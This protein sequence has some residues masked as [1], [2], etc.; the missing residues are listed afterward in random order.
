MKA[1]FALALALFVGAC[2][3]SCT[4]IDL[5][6]NLC[7]G[8]YD[9]GWDARVAPSFEACITIDPIEQIEYVVVSTTTTTTLEEEDE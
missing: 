1:P 8:L 3:G 9:S 6:Y 5:S 4:Q 7:G 2:M